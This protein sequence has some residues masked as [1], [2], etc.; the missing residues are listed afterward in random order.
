MACSV[1]EMCPLSL[2]SA[3]SFFCFAILL[4]MFMQL[5]WELNMQ[6]VWCNHVPALSGKGENANL[7]FIQF[8]RA[9]WYKMI[10]SLNW[11]ALIWNHKG[12]WNTQSSVICVFNS[13]VWL[14][15]D[16]YLSLVPQMMESLCFWS[17]L[18]ME[19]HITVFFSGLFC[20]AVSYEFWILWV[21]FWEWA[22]LSRYILYIM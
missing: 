6:S 3:H 8:S 10:S 9:P 13:T 12:N 16:H 22:T 17:L 15:L 21:T 7:N 1:S 19:C 5:L 20:Y 2:A 14:R 18:K 4:I 11:C